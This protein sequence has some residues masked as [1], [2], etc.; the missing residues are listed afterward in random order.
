MIFQSVRIGCVGD[1]IPVFIDFNDEFD[2][3]LLRF[4]GKSRET[5]LGLWQ[6]LDKPVAQ[7]LTQCPCNCG[8]SGEW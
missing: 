4:L 1:L 2:M 5:A 6:W 3:L 7:Q 8:T